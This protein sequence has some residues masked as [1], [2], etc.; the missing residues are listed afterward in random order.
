MQLLRLKL[1]NFQGIKDF[2][3][4]PNGNDAVVFGDNETGKTTLYNAF[5]WLLFDKA[6]TGEAGFSPK[7]LDKDGNEIH[8]IENTVEGVFRCHDGQIITFR[9]T[10]REDWT[11]KRGSLTGTFSGNTTDY[12]INEVPVPK[13][14]YNN[15]L[16]SLFS[17]LQAQVLTHYAYFPE[18]MK[19]QD[20]RKL[21]LE[22]CGDISDEAVVQN[23]EE[24]LKELPSTLLMPGTTDRFYTVE[25]YQKIASSR[26]K[27]INDR[28]DE[29]PRQINEAKRAVPDVSGISREVVENSLEV[30]QKEKS[31]LEAKKAAVSSSSAAQELRKEIADRQI[32]MIRLKSEHL[33]KNELAVQTEE[34]RILTLEHSVSQHKSKLRNEEA[35]L[36]SLKNAL[37]KAKRERARLSEEFKELSE[38]KWQGDTV[39]PTCRQAFP[40][41]HIAE[42]KEMFN[43]DKSKRLE[44]IRKAAE[45]YCSK[46][47]IAQMERDADRKQSELEEIIGAIAH[48][49]NTISEAK[50][51]LPKP[52]AW[53]DT[54]EYAD[55]KA[56]L[57]T[58]QQ[59]LDE[60]DIDTAEQKKAMQAEIDSVQSRISEQG[61]K[62]YLLKYAEKQN[63][64]VSDLEKEQKQTAKE[65]EKL[66]RGLYLC[67]EFIRAKVSMLTDNIN[68]RFERVK[69]RLFEDQINGGLKECC[70]V[71]VPSKNG[72]VNFSS[73]NNA[74][75]INA[76][77][78]L[79]STLS[80]YWGIEMPVFVDN[81]EGVQKVFRT[82]AQMIQTVVPLAW[83]KL[84]AVTRDALA[85][86]Y[87]SED[88]AREA[89]EAP[90]KTLRVE[91][92]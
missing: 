86:V 31:E 39:C 17:P 37:D 23:N 41:E 71:M 40:D 4:E 61:E 5:M 55:C 35:T 27:G 14:D 30:L 22:V 11:K 75:R 88:T 58:L 29:L 50:D 24:M 36:D 90:N 73:A 67:D 69:F 6:S 64:R 43:L 76:G 62:L 81:S 10:Y 18:T 47:K 34:R 3:F 72:L 91:V 51:K 89:Y 60:G 80:E 66:E 92:C 59:R 8:N 63:S 2:V 79:I 20:R 70:E 48:L 85:E 49:N 38:K 42:I 12:Y 83:D 46:D 68:N 78:E 21:L 44:E 57:A 33:K 16:K 15:R 77:L 65:K 45:A 13:Y 54:A 74:G 1:T 53:E 19:W 84:G 28:L 9:K 52:L 87:G 82:K 7:T 25:E 56:K 26:L 32:D